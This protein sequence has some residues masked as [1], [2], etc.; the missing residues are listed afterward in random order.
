MITFGLSFP[1]YMRFLISLI[2]S[3]LEIGLFQS[4]GKLV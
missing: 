2:N 4:K 1:H 3:F